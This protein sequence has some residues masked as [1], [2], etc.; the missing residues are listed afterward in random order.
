MKFC[1]PRQTAAHLPWIGIM[2][3]SQGYL[4]NYG[5]LTYLKGDGSVWIT[6]EEDGGQHHGDEKI[7]QLDGFD[8]GGDEF[9]RFDCSLQLYKTAPMA[10]LRDESFCGV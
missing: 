2:V 9:M 5:H 7:G 1:H 6:V 3:R 8:L 10:A 4:A